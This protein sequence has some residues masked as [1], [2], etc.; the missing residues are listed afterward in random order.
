MWAYQILDRY[1]NNEFPVNAEGI[2][3][4]MGIEVHRVVI[5]GNVAGM[6]LKPSYEPSP[7]IFVNPA[8]TEARIRFTIAHELGHYIEET[9]EKSGDAQKAYGYADG[10]AEDHAILAGRIPTKT[11]EPDSR[12]SEIF[13]DA[14]AHALLMPEWELDSFSGVGASTN[15]LANYFGVSAVTMANRQND[16]KSRQ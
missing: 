1:W 5:P 11:G 3:N 14:F 13:A 6:L 9:L 8:A 12:P 2:A 15:E 16:L 10:Y 4:D 7:T